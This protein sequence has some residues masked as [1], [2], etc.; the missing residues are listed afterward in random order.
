MDKLL[1]PREAGEYLNVTEKTLANARW[2]GIGVTPKFCKIG[3]S[4]RYKQS[5]LDAYIE[6]HTHRNT[7]EAKELHNE[8]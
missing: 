5:E 3:R 8:I 1:T 7:G 6:S 4:I 2:S